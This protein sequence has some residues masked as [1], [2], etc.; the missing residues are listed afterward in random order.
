MPKCIVANTVKGK[1]VPNMENNYGQ[2]HSKV[3]S[4]LELNEIM[5]AID[6]Y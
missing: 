3:P 4:D 1:G 6:N 2:W 5:V